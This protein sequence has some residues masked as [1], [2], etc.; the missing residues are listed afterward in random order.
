MSIFAEGREYILSKTSSVR[1]ANPAR[2]RAAT[3]RA[4][5]TKSRKRMCFTRTKQQ[6]LQSTLWGSSSSSTTWRTSG[7]KTSRQSNTDERLMCHGMTAKL[8]LP[9]PTLFSAKPYPAMLMDT[10]PFLKS[11]LKRHYFHSSA[12]VVLIAMDNPGF[13]R[14]MVRSSSSSLVLGIGTGGHKYKKVQQ[15]KESKKQKWKLMVEQNSLLPYSCLEKDRKSY[16]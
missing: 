15:E 8:S 5:C 16:S 10:S 3:S 13:P 6:N 11:L 14:S 12:K 4:S 9:G 2:Y 7:C 1:H